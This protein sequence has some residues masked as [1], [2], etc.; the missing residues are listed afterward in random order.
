MGTCELCP[1]PLLLPLCLA[2]LVQQRGDLLLQLCVGAGGL[3]D[4]ALQS[5]L[6]LLQLL[7]VDFRFGQVLELVGAVN[8]QNSNRI[9][10]SAQCQNYGVRVK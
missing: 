7:H 6:L 1:H 8:S 9:M 5:R 2:A 3:R 10:T 4:L